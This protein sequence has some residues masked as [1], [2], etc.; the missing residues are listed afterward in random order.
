LRFGAEFVTAWS[1]VLCGHAISPR[2]GQTCSRCGPR[3]IFD[4]LIDYEKLERSGFRVPGG[5][6]GDHWRFG[7]LLPIP[8]VEPPSLRVGGTPLVPVPAL[9]AELG[10]GELWI[11][12]ESKN[13]SGSLK[14]R[15]S[16][17]AVALARLSGASAV[18]CA[19]TGNAASSLAAFAA[20]SGIRSYVFVPATTPREKLL[21]LAA[22]DATV[23][24]ADSYEQAFELCEQAV[25]AFGWFDRNAA[26]D[27]RLVE[28]KK[29][30]GLEIGQ[31]LGNRPPDW[32]SVAVGDGCTIAG[33][34]K[35]LNEAARFGSL[36]ALPRLLGTQASAAAPLARAFAAG[37]S[38][39]DC[40]GA[41]SLAGSIA[42]SDP[43]NGAKA[44]RAVRESFGA[45]VEVDDEAMLSAQ[46]RL[47]ANGLFAEP[48]AAAGIAG[49]LRC[50]EEGRLGPQDRV[51]HVLTG[52]VPRGAVAPDRLSRHPI[53]VRSL[54]EVA[55]VVL[56]AR[57][58]RR[59]R[60]SPA[61]T[62]F[63][64]NRRPI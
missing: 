6:G 20:N 58:G 30:C 9:A 31:E 14:D 2:Q 11:K 35:G 51:V 36:G 50:R 16:S 53:N 62:S 19:S 64:P 37:T 12:D 7:P 43:R 8:D 3:G 15:A 34:W 63:G 17:V 42:V 1:C 49:I 56:A 46:R 26:L 57:P 23:L 28:G 61:T 60:E 55:D 41:P 48:A 22:F 21:Q 54:V 25:A 47:G 44:L 24:L 45:F 5:V 39:W 52:G 40:Y 38:D 29:T 10:I 18:A 32:V 59:A 13:A 33:I 27:P 4:V